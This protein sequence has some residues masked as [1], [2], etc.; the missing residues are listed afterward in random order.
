MYQDEP[1]F[2]SQNDCYLDRIIANYSSSR[3]TLVS[4]RQDNTNTIS[5]W[6]FY[7]LIRFCIFLFSMLPKSI[8]YLF[9]KVLTL[10]FYKLSKR[11]RLITIDNLQYA[12]PKKSAE[13]VSILA[14][15]VFVEL[16]KTLAEIILMLSDR[17]DIDEA[18]VNK[19][20]VLLKLK[21]LRTQYPQG[22]IMLTA[23]FSNWE[24]LANFLAKHGYPMLAIGREGDNKLI[25]KH[26]TIPFREKYGNR[27]IYKKKA[28]ISILKALKK[29]DIVGLLIDQKVHKSEGI[30]VKFFE[31]EVYSTGLVATMKNKLDIEVLPLF[32]AR[33]ADGKYSII[34]QDPIREK[35]DIREMT[36]NYN[37]VMQSVIT[38][39]PSQWFWMH[40]RWKV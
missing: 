19:D 20:E 6:F 13:E 24:L 33:I 34:I 21:A 5:D 35:G 27:A 17:F 31:R 3:G 15:E 12:F 14:R 11:R 10:S 9:T 36:Q 37:D 29:G 40:D 39:Y 30:R 8:I 7:L 2:A 23:H 25:D 32:I 26:I 22:W 1:L 38:R 18:V 4:K 16:S 28:A